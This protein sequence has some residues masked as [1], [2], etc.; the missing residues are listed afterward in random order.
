[1]SLIISAEPCESGLDNLAYNFT[2][3]K[4]R[5][6]LIRDDEE[7]FTL[8]TTTDAYGAKI[9]RFWANSLTYCENKKDIPKFLKDAVTL[10]TS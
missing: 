2:H 4:T 3:R 7:S 5:Y 10:I 1:M 8:W 9:K 6:T